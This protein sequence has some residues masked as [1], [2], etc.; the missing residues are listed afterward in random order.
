[1]NSV[2][3]LIIW[4]A[5]RTSPFH[6]HEGNIV[7]VYF[8]DK[9]ACEFALANV[10]ERA[11]RINGVCVPEGSRPNSPGPGKSGQSRQVRSDLR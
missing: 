4:S 2:Y 6:N 10:I 5:F 3:L 9:P 8:H 11:K 1:M 7:V